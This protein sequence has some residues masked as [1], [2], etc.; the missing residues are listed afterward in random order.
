MDTLTGDIDVEDYDPAVR[1]VAMPLDVAFQRAMYQAD[2]CLLT[3]R[4]NMCVIFK[5]GSRFAVF[6]SHARGDDGC[7]QPEGTS[8]VAYYDSLNA[9]YTHITNLVQSLYACDA[10]V[11]DKLFEVTGVKAVVERGSTSDRGVHGSSAFVLDSDEVSG[12]G[13]GS[14]FEPEAAVLVSETNARNVMF[15]CLTLADKRSICTKLGI[16]PCFNHEDVVV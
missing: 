12:E 11:S 9:L 3:I 13:C 6:D 2:A 5:Q 16:A 8:I 14:D 7:W 4:K 10:H 15:K 1:D